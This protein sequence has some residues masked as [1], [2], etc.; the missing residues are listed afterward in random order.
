MNRIEQ[1]HETLLGSDCTTSVSYW[2]GVLYSNKSN[3]DNYDRFCAI[4]QE[5]QLKVM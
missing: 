2:F 4:T 1:N 3:L 5:I